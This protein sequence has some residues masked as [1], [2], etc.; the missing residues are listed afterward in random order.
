MAESWGYLAGSYRGDISH[1]LVIF[2]N[3]RE[4][5]NVIVNDIFFIKMNYLVSRIIIHTIDQEIAIQ[6]YNTTI[7]YPIWGKLDTDWISTAIWPR[8]AEDVNVEI[9][10]WSA[11]FFRQK[12]GRYL[13]LTIG[14]VSHNNHL[15]V[16]YVFCE[17]HHTHAVYEIFCIHF[18]LYGDWLIL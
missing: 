6:F 9:Q 7:G 14:I 2:I 16:S 1:F 5:E 13:K 10:G 8:G 3:I 18:S 17:I 12:W 11:F 4:Y 15:F